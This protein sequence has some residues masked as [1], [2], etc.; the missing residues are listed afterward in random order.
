VSNFYIVIHVFQLSQ[1]SLL[2]VGSCFQVHRAVRYCFFSGV[3]RARAH[4]TVL[5]DVTI[6]NGT[7]TASVTAAKFG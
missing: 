1:Y 6:G 7:L 3:A 2:V 5:C 4:P